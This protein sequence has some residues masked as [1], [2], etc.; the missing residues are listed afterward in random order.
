ME[1][2]NTHTTNRYNALNQAF[3]QMKFAAKYSTRPVSVHLILKKHLN[4]AE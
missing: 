2:K 3:V 4:T 1:I